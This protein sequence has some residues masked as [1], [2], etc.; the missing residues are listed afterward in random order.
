MIENPNLK[1]P[2]YSVIVLIYHRTPELVAMARDC[3][4]SVKNSSQDYELIIC[5]NGSTEKY[6]WVSECDTYIR[7]NKNMGISRGW[8]AGLRLARGKYYAVIGDDVIVRKGWLEALQEAMDMPNAGIANVHVEHLPQGIGVVENYKW[9]S[10]ACFMITQKTIQKVGYYDQDSYYPANW[11]DVDYSTRIYK[12][13]LK[14]YVNYGFSVQHLEGQT[15]HAPD[16]ASHFDRLRQVFIDKH[17]FDPTPA[18]YGNAS[19]YDLLH[20]VR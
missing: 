1:K 7:F 11:E 20:K 6:D 10:H 2:K 14:C 16:L 8:N 12:A 5:D 4:A 13:G 19:L 3:I 18:F 15:V 9:F 17:G